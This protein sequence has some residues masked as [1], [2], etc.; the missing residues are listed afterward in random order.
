M[1]VGWCGLRS[2]GRR[3]SSSSRRVELSFLKVPFNS[4]PGQRLPLTRPSASQLVSHVITLN[5]TATRASHWTVAVVLTCRARPRPAVSS[6]MVSQLFRS[7]EAGDVE[8][9]REILKE[10]SSI[11]IETKGESD[12]HCHRVEGGSCLASGRPHA[13]RREPEQVGPR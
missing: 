7:A 8:K 1:R 11:D 3:F 2:L 12:I 10:S 4:S 6:P 13:S 9:V 5:Q